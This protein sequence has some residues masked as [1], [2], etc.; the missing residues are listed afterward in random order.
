MVSASAA[1]K[2]ILFGEHAVVYGRP[3]IAIPISDRRAT[4]S[5]IPLD[6]GEGIWIVAEDLAETYRLDRTYD[7]DDRARPLQVTVRNVLEHLDVDPEQE[8]LRIVV[9]SRIPIASGLGSGTAVATAMVRAL[10]AHY[11]RD[12]APEMV[13]CLVYETEVLLHGTPS[14]IDNTVVAY[15]KPVCFRQGEVEFFSVKKTLTLLVADTGIPSRTR[16][17]VDAV[18]KRW[19]EKR[20]TYEMLFDR[21]GDL[22]ERAREALEDGDLSRVG[23]LMNA[24]QN[25]LSQLRVS[26]PALNTL[27]EAAHRAGALGAKL[28]G[29]G[30]GGCMLALAEEET[31]Q[32]IRRALLDA[33]AAEVM[34]T[35]VSAS[36]V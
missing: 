21:I 12:L 20:R 24:N 15:E 6:G 27:V 23:R 11:G 33:G 22:T 16:D 25:L 17:T 34:A 13:S 2:A 3:A 35:S 31:R 10:A 4:A 8:A 7:D 29:G 1:G 9:H 30:R 28:S 36:F 26:S 19:Q 18:R 5:A 14:G 32:N